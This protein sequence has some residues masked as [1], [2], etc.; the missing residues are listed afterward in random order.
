MKYNDNMTQHTSKETK[1]YRDP[2]GE[3]MTAVERLVSKENAKYPSPSTVY[4]GFYASFEAEGKAGSVYLGG[5]EGIIGTQV[6]FSA[7]GFE[8]GQC[9]EHGA[10]Q[11]A[12]QGFASGQGAGQGADGA[13]DAPA[14]Q[15]DAGH[16]GQDCR[17][18]LTNAAGQTIGYLGDGDSRRITQHLGD[19]WKV[20]AVLSLVLFHQNEKKTSGEVGCICYAPD[21]APAMEAFAANIAY[22]IAKGEH[23]SL[24]LNHDQL[25]RVLRSEGAWY[26]TKHQALPELP[27]GTIVHKRR[28]S[29]GE[30]LVEQAYKGNRGCKAAGIL[31][32]PLLAI[33][34]V[35]FVWWFFLR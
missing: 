28:R 2:L 27:A 10:G 1:S 4:E 12:G 21:I 17:I 34:I 6:A 9:A 31:F 26:L 16:A 20:V 30:G 32:W 3:H 22:R 13:Q 18:A 5:A 29:A 15:R 25:I 33:I 11:G 23:P 14:G 24:A 35:F 19:G 8:A 7:A